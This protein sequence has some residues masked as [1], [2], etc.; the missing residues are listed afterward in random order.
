MAE[1]TRITLDE[2]KALLGMIDEPDPQTSADD[3]RQ[4]GG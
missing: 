1:P 4:M 3:R 2:I